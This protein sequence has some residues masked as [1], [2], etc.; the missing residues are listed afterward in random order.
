[1]EP[2]QLQEKPH[3]ANP[4]R[5]D[6][7]TDQ[8]D[9][10]DQAMQESETWHTLE[11]RHDCRTLIQAL[12]IRRPCVQRAAGYVQH[13]GRLTLGEALRF[14]TAILCTQ[15]GT[16]DALPALVTIIVAL[17]LVV[18]Y[19]GHSV[20]LSSTLRRCLMLAH[21]GEA[22]P[23]GTARTSQGPGPLRRRSSYAHTADTSRPCQGYQPARAAE[24]QPC[25]WRCRMGPASRAPTGVMG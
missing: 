22:L 15:L 21:N 2:R 8:V 20:L 23:Y 9:G 24:S 10:Q 19:S 11:K 12:L 17:W 4:T 13:L 14:E 1:M 5:T 3:Q 16:C 6:L 25:C 18:D 7:D